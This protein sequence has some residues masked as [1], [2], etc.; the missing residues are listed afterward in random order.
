MRQ[1]MLLKNIQLFS[2]VL[3]VVCIGCDARPLQDIA[4]ERGLPELVGAKA[5][6]LH[7]VEVEFASVP[8][9]NAEQAER[10]SIRSTDG[11]ALAVKGAFR[12]EGERNIVLQTEAHTLSE[13]TLSVTALESTESAS[14][15]TALKEVTYTGSTAIEPQLLSA[16]A[17]SNTSVLLT[18]DVKMDAGTAGLA[19][20]YRI[21]SP[22]LN[23]TAASLASDGQSLTLTTS[24]QSDVLYNVRVAGVKTYGSTVYVDPEFSNPTFYGIARTDVTSPKLIKAEATSYTTVR[25]SFSEPVENFAI[26]SANYVITP[27]VTVL[28]A[29]LNEYSTQV[30]LTTLPLTLGTPYS[31]AVSNVEDRAGRVIDALFST[32]AFTFNGAV[33][34]PTYVGQPP[35]VI[36]AISINNL[37]VDVHFSKPMGESAANIERY[38]ITGPDTTFLFVEQATLSTDR[39]T[40]RL[41]T[42]SQADLLYTVQ[43]AGVKD[44]DGNALAPPSS[45]LLVI[46]GLDPTKAN[47]FG[48]P[49]GSI[50][51]QIDTDGDGFADWFENAGWLITIQ[52]ANGGTKV[53]FV[54][55]D[56]NNPD[57]DGDG[58]TDGEEN[59]HNWDPRTND[60]DADILDDFTEF[61]VLFSDPADQDSDDDGIDDLTE[62]TF[63]F[64]SPIIADTDGDQMSDSEELFDRSRNPLIADLPLPQITVQEI[65]LELN[66][67][68]SF[69]DE[70][71][72]TSSI[73]DSTSTTFT[74]SSTDTLGTSETNSTESENTFGQK[75][76]AEGGTGGFKISGEVSFGQ[77]LGQGFSSTVDRQSSETAQQEYQQSVTQALEQS[78]SRSVT[79]TIDSAIV[80]ATVNISNN[81]DIAFSI[82]NLELS[83][84]Q[85]DRVT[86]L[87]FRPIA[88]MRPTAASDPTG[89]PVY[90]IAPLEQNRGPIIFENATVFPNRIDDLMREPT[91]LVFKVVNFDVSDE[92]GRNLVFTA[93]EVADHTAAITIDFG[94]GR[95]ELYRVATASDFDADGLPSGITMQRALEIAGILK[96][97]TPAADEA[98]T[99]KTIQD[100]RLDENNAPI[101][102]EALVRI[103]DVEKSADGRKFWTAVTNNT[104]LDENADFS[105]IV[106]HARDTI[107]LMYTSDDDEDGLFLREEY[108]YGSDDTLDDTDEDTIPDFDEVRVGWLVARVPGL[109]YKTFPSPARPDSDL[110]GTRDDAERFAKTD[111]NRADTDEDGRSDTSELKDTYQIVLFDADIDPSN[112]KVLSVAPYSDWVIAAGP[113]GTCNTTTLSGDD[114]ALSYVV[115][116]P[117]SRLCVHAGLNGII[118]T[119]PSGDDVV[120]AA[121]K[122]DAGPNGFCETLSVVGDDIIEYRLDAQSNEYVPQARFVLGPICVSAGLNNVIDTPLAGDDFVR[123]V[124]K[125]L[126]GTNPVN[127]DTDIDGVPDGREVILGINPNTKDAGNVIDSDGD[128]LFDK[129]EEDGWAV[130]GYGVVSSDKNTSDTDH[131]GIPDVLERAIGS[132]PNKLD[133]DGDTLLDYKELNVNNPLVNNAP[134]YNSVALATALQRC[135]DA[136][137]CSYVVPPV[138]QV[139]GTNPSSV[140]SDGDGRNDNLELNIPWNVTVYGGSPSQVYSSPRFSDHDGDGLNDSAELANLSNPEVSDTDSDGRQDGAEV[141]ASLNP[142]R[143][144]KRI[145]VT[146]TN[147]GVVNDCDGPTL[148]GLE[149][150]GSFE[151]QKPDGTSF[152]FKNFPCVGEGLACGGGCCGGDRGCPTHPFPVSVSTGAFVFREGESFELTSGVLIDNDGACGCCPIPQT[153]GT[154]SETISFSLTLETSRAVTV[155]SSE[156][157][158]CEI[159]VNYVTTILN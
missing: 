16:V 96:D 90:N 43:A 24:P 144:D 116:F 157:Q 138:S 101:S 64:T 135:S 17:L 72:T 84:L 154:V 26:D 69:T 112:N 91:G 56:P 156:S 126:F 52:L 89:Q 145:S 149:L 139:S 61:N 55:S 114:A 57:T 13:Y 40:V 32:A 10:Y 60:T 85:Q 83:L 23:I 68:S 78:E 110:D 100:A 62:V 54:T 51:E 44:L 94:D 14:P 129:E 134:L 136:T 142:L 122:V 73:T 93:Q 48:S 70:E 20:R 41:K 11:A 18:Y 47:F 5:L 65:A 127:R 74:Q 33:T 137:I 132:H 53:A 7:Y 82:T 115:N 150:E 31:V 143:K 125:G 19:N 88:T 6:S 80:Q 133:T 29:A 140:D 36:G 30:L 128:G 42:T 97:N 9:A 92:F 8:G 103:R 109:P 15:T 1:K 105:T 28:G 50:D 146:L 12:A 66:I 148:D 46:V 63:F 118:D 76:A 81:S 158:G 77:S 27:S 58:F 2:A 120:V 79:R 39:T 3:T 119:S 107:L 25:L 67:T 38:R 86:G 155:G 131:D 4:A 37:M 159:T 45:S 99:Y 152:T 104:D 147:I 111:P 117:G 113:N 71:G 98:H 59:A 95:V 87:S 21:D 102:V 123:A 130:T 106:L 121:P 108:L 49:P 34:E 35:R 141:S 75:I 151:I 153:I 22:D 124:H